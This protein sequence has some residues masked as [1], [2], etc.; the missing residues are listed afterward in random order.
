VATAS[1]AI[2]NGLLFPILF[3]SG[4]F[5]PVDSGSWLARI[6][7]VFPIRH[8]EEAVF[9]VFDPRVQGSGVRVEALLVMLAWGIGR[10]RHRGP[11]LPLGAAPKVEELHARPRLELSLNLSEMTR[12]RGG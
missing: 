5:F 10:G 6:A 9:T 12:V 3:I 4:T 1:P 8:F 2:V 11:G 7:S